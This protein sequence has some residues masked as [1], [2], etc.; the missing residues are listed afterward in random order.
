MSFTIS[1]TLNIDDLDTSLEEDIVASLEAAATTKLK[2]IG[3]SDSE[4][5]TILYDDDLIQP[6]NVLVTMT[7][8]WARRNTGWAGCTVD[9]VEGWENF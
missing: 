1:I 5:K 7:D 6:I 3:K 2:A 8:Y 9:K 4:I